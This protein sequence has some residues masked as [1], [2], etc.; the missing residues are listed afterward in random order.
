[1]KRLIIYIYFMYVYLICSEFDNRKLYKIGFTRRPIEKR[2]NEI[3]TSNGGE[4][5]LI[6]SYE[7][8]YGT[9]IE[10][11]LHKIFKDK[12]VNREW[13]DLDDN[14]INSFKTLCND[15]H[16]IFDII[17]NNNTYY[18]DKGSFI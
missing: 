1:M 6:D 18:Q 15:T 4:I 9:K 10:S 7:S 14:D 3:K 16:I 13:F 5:Y 8:E 17:V 2:I 11:K 12:K